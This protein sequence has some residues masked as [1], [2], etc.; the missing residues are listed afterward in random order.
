VRRYF[1]T[2]LAVLAAVIGVI[3]LAFFRQPTL[4]LDLQGGLELVLQAQAPQGQQVTKEDMER[5]V[6]IIRSRVDKLGVSE[7]EVR[8]QGD[9]QIAVDLAGVTN[10]ARAAEIVGKTAQLQFYDLEADLIAPSKDAR[11]FPVA[12]PR[13]KPLLTAEDKLK[14]ADEPVTQWYLF[15]GNTLLSGPADKK[16][17]LAQQLEGGRVPEGAT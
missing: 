7:P 13:L 2:L 10:P 1:W 11:G 5:S 12:N 17:D 8:Q 6:E 3:V 9:D 16:E 14:A 4:G 15:Q